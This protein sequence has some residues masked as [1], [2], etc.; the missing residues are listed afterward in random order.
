MQTVLSLAV[1]W[2]MHGNEAVEPR[3]LAP[4]GEKEGREGL[5]PVDIGEA[6]FLL[7]VE[8][9]SSLRVVNLARGQKARA[10]HDFI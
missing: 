1:S 2:H 4:D 5:P 7:P 3:R 9:C 8:D 6:E 10:R